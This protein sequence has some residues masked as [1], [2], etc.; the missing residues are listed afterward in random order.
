VLYPHFFNKIY[1][2]ELIKGR[3]LRIK[4]VI[5]ILSMLFFQIFILFKPLFSKI[6]HKKWEIHTILN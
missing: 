3:L 5:F 1:L 2:Q 6:Y 4:T